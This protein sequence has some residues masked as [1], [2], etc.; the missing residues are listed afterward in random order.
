M[1]YVIGAIAGLAIGCLISNL[2]TGCMLPDVIFGSLATL[3]GA[4][5]S[6]YLRKSKFLVFVFPDRSG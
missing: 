5:G 2:I 1:D 4:V 6:W 3:I